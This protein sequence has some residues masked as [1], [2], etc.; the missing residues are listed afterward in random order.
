MDT[1]LAPSTSIQPGDRS[2]L[3]TVIDTFKKDRAAEMGTPHSGRALDTLRKTLDTPRFAH[4][5]GISAILTKIRDGRSRMSGPGVRSVEDEVLADLEAL[6]GGRRKT[7]RRRGRGPRRRGGAADEFSQVNPM[8]KKEWNE[9]RKG[10]E[11]RGETIR[12]MGPGLLRGDL[13]RQNEEETRWLEED[14]RRAKIPGSARRKVRLT[15]RR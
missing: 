3:G 13:K 14:M 4:V 9:T 11:R 5:D 7:R 2:D 15:R 1:R 12:R 8:M 6:R 10:I